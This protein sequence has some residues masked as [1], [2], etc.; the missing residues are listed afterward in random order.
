MK[1]S[2]SDNPQLLD[3]IRFL[4]K[5]AKEN[6]AQIWNSVADA[7]SKPRSRRKSVNLSRINRHTEKGQAVAIAGKVLGSGTLRHPVTVAAFNF[8]AAS[9]KK[10]KKVK[11]KCMTFPEL[12]KKNPKGS[13]IKIVG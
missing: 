2:K 10:I 7:L 11:G 1:K 12:V 9:K 13:N 8:S 4:K 6:D 3:L 5:A